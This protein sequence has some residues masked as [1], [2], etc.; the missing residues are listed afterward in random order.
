MFDPVFSCKVAGTF[1]LG[2]WAGYN[3]SLLFGIGPRT[4]S[5]VKNSHLL[6][7]R[8]ANCLKEDSSTT[9]SVRAL[10]SVYGAL[11]KSL[12]ISA[13]S[14]FVLLSEFMAY[15]LSR[16]SLRHPYLLYIALSAPLVGALQFYGSAKLAS[17]T[18][19]AINAAEKLAESEKEPILKS[20]EPESRCTSSSSLQSSDDF[21]HINAEEPT[22]VSANVEITA[23]I[24]ET[25]DKEE[26]EINNVAAVNSE[27]IE[28]SITQK[29][30]LF[31]SVVAGLS[32]F[33]SL[34]SV[35][36]LA[37]DRA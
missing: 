2:L 32:S 1:S 15:Q 36:G 5:N 8:C 26:E 14:G 7:S 17:Q 20:Q 18:K 12:H 31:A 37:G 22:S 28:F 3:C 13:I 35:I 4:Y 10:H 27:P 23:E 16:C 29:Y 21:E 11:M 25:P 9:S 30:D 6:P 19:E 24:N 34:V 33:L